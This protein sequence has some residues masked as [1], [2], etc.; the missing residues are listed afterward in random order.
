MITLC[1]DDTPVWRIQTGRAP[2]QHLS[3]SVPTEVLQLSVLERLQIA[4]HPQALSRP[5]AG[6]RL[7]ELCFVTSSGFPG[8][9]IKVVVEIFRDSTMNGWAKGGLAPGAVPRAGHHS[10]GLRHPRQE[11][12]AA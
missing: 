10:P 3:A 9:T 1:I 12:D 5:S 6:R 7:P 8:R 11:H 2:S 4:R